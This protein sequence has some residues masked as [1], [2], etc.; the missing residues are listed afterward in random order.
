MRNILPTFFISV[1]GLVLL[2]GCASRPN[3]IIIK[4]AWARPA[5]AGSN[6]AVYFTLENPLHDS[7]ALIK[8]DGE[9]AESVELHESTMDDQGTMMMRPLE[10]V[11]I[12][13]NSKVEFKPGGLHVMLFKLKR[14]L[15][16]GDQFTLTF[17]FQAHPDLIQ[18]IL[19]KDPSE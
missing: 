6:S 5:K 13:A 16:A 2:S 4:D 17:H 1:L 14:D 15:N 3:E 7:E 8:V 11:P 18:Q 12:N 10:T 19:V 9:V